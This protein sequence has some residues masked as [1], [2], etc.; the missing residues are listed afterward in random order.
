V[1]VTITGEVEFNQIN[2]GPLAAVNAGETATTSFIIDSSVFDD[3]PNF[4]TRGYDIDQ[5][6]FSLAFDSVTVGLQAPFPIGQT[7]YFV[8]RN[9]DPAV[10]GFFLSTIL[11]G[12]MGVPTDVTGG[13]G[14][15]IDAFSVT[16]T[17]DTL[18]SLNILD[19]LGTYDFTNLTVF[20][21]TID[22]GPF[23]PL[24]IVFEQMTIAEP[25]GNAVPA[26]STWGAMVLTIAITVAGTLVFRRRQSA[27]LRR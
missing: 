4:P 11:D 15:F 23:N 21:Y 17:G 8:I 14:Q 7:P 25:A 19:A 27:D 10:D 5:G 1:E 2:S 9:D 18:T 13:F 20:N 26:V 24:G 22:D 3:N 6:S 16:Y 12:P